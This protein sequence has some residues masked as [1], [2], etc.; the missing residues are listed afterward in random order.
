MKNKTLF[1]LVFCL[2]CCGAG[3]AQQAQAPNLYRLQGGHVHVTYSTSGVPHFTYQDAKQT[4]QFSGQQIQTSST[5]IGTLVTVTIRMTVDTGS[6]SF[7]LLVPKVNLKP[8]KAAAISTVGITT[9]HKFS[10]V[11]MM[12]EGQVELYT[13]TALSGTAAVMP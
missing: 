7:T 8:G 12:N 5:S 4:L 13:T 11:P 6:T 10:V 3:F 2:V 9:S 1:L